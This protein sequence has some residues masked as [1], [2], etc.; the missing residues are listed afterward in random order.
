MFYRLVDDWLV[1]YTIYIW[2]YRKISETLMG[3][4]MQPQFNGILLLIGPGYDVIDTKLLV[5]FY[6]AETQTSLNGFDH[7]N[8]RYT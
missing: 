6:L 2:D 1:G 4:P 5:F 8:M 3:K 7:L